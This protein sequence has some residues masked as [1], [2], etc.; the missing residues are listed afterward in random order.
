M[1]VSSPHIHIYS[2]ETLEEDLQRAGILYCQEHVEINVSKREVVL[3]EI[4]SKYASDFGKTRDEI[5]IWLFQFLEDKRRI[6]IL[7][8]MKK[9]C[10]IVYKASIWA[11]QVPL[12]NSMHLMSLVTINFYFSNFLIK[13]F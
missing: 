11:P 1:S 3:P 7:P 5:M 4:F 10:N 2:P 9:G 8:L 12:E 6:E 13:F